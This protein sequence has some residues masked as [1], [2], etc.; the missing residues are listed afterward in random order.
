MK[1]L[2]DVCIVDARRIPFCKSGTSYMGLSNR[3]LLKPV[4]QGLVNDLGLEGE[5]I[6][7]VSLGAV[8]KHARDWNMAREATIDAG[9][10]LET[11]A[12]DIQKACGT[13]LE[14]VLTLGAKIAI[15]QIDSAIAAGSD[16]NSDLPIEFSK[17]MSDRLLA[18]NYAKTT[19]DKLMALKGLMPKD[20][21]PQLPSVNEQRTKLSMG[22]STEIMAKNWKI[23]REAQDQLAVESHQ[24]AAKAYEDG[25][26]DKMVIPFQG[27]KT[28]PLVRPGTNLEKLAKLKPAFDKSGAGTLTAGNSTALTDGAAAVF[29]CSE[30]YA[31]ERG[32]PV[33]A[34]LVMGE[35]AA[36]DYVSGRDGLLIAP[37]FAVARMLKR[38]GLSLGD[39]D[40]YEFHE[41]FAAQ[42][43]CT[44]K[45]F[46]DEAFS[47]ERL[48][49]EGALGSVDRTKLNLKGGSLALGHPFAA[50]GA[51]IVGSLAHQLNQRGGGRGLISICTAGGMG[52]TAILE[53]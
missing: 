48:Q 11:P 25:F 27:L 28:D 15:G 42:V 3:D 32:L 19:M 26:Y 51:R 38:A 35:S 8:N 17:K 6:G 12:F 46:E 4:M 53:A 33:L 10:S 9:L 1:T 40:L 31:K 22:Q 13:S 41:A 37:V 18:M 39:F 30:D 45:A 52:V 43:L 23:T 20:L 44:F 29:L 24:K 5:R 14:T 50:T 36:V 2:R 21:L 49:W 16:T 34:K 7:E 47:R